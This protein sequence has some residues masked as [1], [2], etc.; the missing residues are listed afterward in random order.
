MSTVMV[1][2]TGLVEA[3]SVTDDEEWHRFCSTAPDHPVTRYLYEDPFTSRAP[4]RPRG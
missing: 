1:D 4:A 3:C 2:D